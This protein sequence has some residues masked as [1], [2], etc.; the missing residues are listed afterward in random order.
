[1]IISHKYKFIFI[2]TSKVAGTSLEMYLDPL[3]GP[4]DVVT[5]F[6]HPESGHC[7]R[8]FKGRF[9][10]S[11]ELAVR[12]QLADRYGQDGRERTLDDLEKE[13]LFFEPMPAWQVKARVSPEI[14]DEYFKFTIERNP[15]EKIVSRF[16]HSKQVYRE[17]YGKELTMDG[18]LS[19]LKGLLDTP[20]ATPTWGSPAPFNL[21]R[22][23][24]PITGELLVDHIVR[25]EELNKGLGE[26][27]S[28]LDLPYEGSLTPRAKGQY[29]RHRK[30]YWEELNPEQMQDVAD[31]FAG[32]IK[33]MGYEQADDR[34]APM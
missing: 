2:K 9:D 23:T 15:W 27:F 6:W 22:Y 34:P 12:D 25:F 8:N 20:W 31:L 3:C 30:P 10:P 29:R 16:H 24:D 1:M 18:F 5:P 28:Q 19:Y 26:V 32:E 7:P 14:W 17:K 11:R 13:N 4:E 21:P 33:R